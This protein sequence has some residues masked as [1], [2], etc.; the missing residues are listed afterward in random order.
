MLQGY[1]IGSFEL[2][3]LMIKLDLKKQNQDV[4]KNRGGL[5]KRVIQ[6]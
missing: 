5:V 2:L 6:M 3:S 4:F 1:H